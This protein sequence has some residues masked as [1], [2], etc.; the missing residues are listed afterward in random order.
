MN[1]LSASALMVAAL[2]VPVVGAVGA[3]ASAT[4][5]PPWAGRTYHGSSR[6]Q[7]GQR[8]GT[9]SL[10][11][12]RDGRSLTFTVPW[13]CGPYTQT[14][15]HKVTVRSNGSFK[16]G[17]NARTGNPGIS[18]FING[19]FTGAPAR[20]AHGTLFGAVRFFEEPGVISDECETGNVAYP[21]IVWSA[22]H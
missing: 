3:P 7:T 16:G 10:R 9:V 5:K 18:F 8:L 20:R 22:A 1:R 13:R 12:A 19:N 14:S 6:L 11:V 4:A 21:G 2:A 15:T 17:V